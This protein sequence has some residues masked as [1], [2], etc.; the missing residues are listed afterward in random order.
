MVK[1][2]P[3]K[4]KSRSEAGFTIYWGESKDNRSVLGDHENHKVREPR[5]MTFE[6]YMASQRRRDKKRELSC[7]RHKLKE[8]KE[9]KTHFLLSIDDTLESKVID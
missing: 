4:N 9:V 1:T 7:H 6:K 2:T 5:I 3:K 8:T